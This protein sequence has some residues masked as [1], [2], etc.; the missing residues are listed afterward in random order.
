MQ[1]SNSGDFFS[2]M[3][4][5]PLY[6]F[7]E[8]DSLEFFAREVGGELHH[9]VRE[10]KFFVRSEATFA[11]DK[12]TVGSYYNGVNKAETADRLRQLRNAGEF[13]PLTLGRYY[14]G[15][16]REGVKGTSEHE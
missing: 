14:N 8:L 16:D 1:A 9:Y 13:L 5:F 11:C 10:T 3:Q 2:P 6:V 7:L 15:G 12:N 4:G